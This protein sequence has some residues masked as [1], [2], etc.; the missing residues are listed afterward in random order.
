M[1]IPTMSPWDRAFKKGNFGFMIFGFLL[2]MLMSLLFDMGAWIVMVDSRKNVK[3][4]VKE[5]CHLMSLMIKPAIELKCDEY[6]VCGVCVR[7]ILTRSFG[8]L[9]G[10]AFQSLME[11]YFMVAWLMYYLSVKSI[12][13]NP[14]G[15]PL[16]QRE[17]EVEAMLRD[18]RFFMIGDVNSYKCEVVVF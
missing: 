17:L 2:D 15:Q 13:A 14:S 6:I 10:L 7:W 18:V 16:G 3:E 5:G 12:D 8:V 1:L 11:V 9:F 4:A